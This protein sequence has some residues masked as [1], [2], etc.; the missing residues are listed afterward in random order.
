MAAT[1][2]QQSIS[3]AGNFDGTLPPGTSAPS[4]DIIR[5][6]PAATGGLFQFS[7][8]RPH[9]LVAVEL[10]L[11]NQTSWT[12]HK[13]DSDG[14]EILLWSGT[15]EQQFVIL[16]QDKVLVLEDELIVVRTVAATT[17]MKCRVALAKL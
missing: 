5:F 10:K 8:T 9:R 16:T 15:T 4:K 14:D 6:P 12:I 1:I 7:L 17:A 11:A 3:A 13:R 2:I